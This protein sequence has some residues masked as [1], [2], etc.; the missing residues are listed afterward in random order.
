VSAA[1]SVQSVAIVGMSLA[2]L[3]CAETLRRLGFDGVIHAIGEEVHEPYDR[4]PLSKDVLAGI[5]EPSSTRLRTDGLADLA[6]DLHL[7]RRATSLRADDRVVTLDDGAEVG[8]DAIVIATGAIARRLPATICPPSLPNVH[9]LRTLDDAVRLRAALELSP[10]RVAVIGAGFIGMEVA[11]ACRSRGLEVTVVEALPQPM[12]RG[13]GELLGSTCAQLHRKHGVQIELGVGVAAVDERGIVLADGRRVDADVVL[14]GVGAEPAV[15]WLAGSGLTIDNGV[16]CDATCTASPGIYAAGDVA[17]W[18]NPLFDQL[19]RLEHW[20]NAVEQGMH[21]AQQIVSGDATEFAPVPFVWSDQY[22]CKIQSVGR[23]DADSDLH[24]AHGALDSYK[25]VAL[26]GH[27]GRVVGA[28]GFSQ[29]RLVTQYRRLIAD[30]ASWDDAL[31]KS[32]TE[33][34]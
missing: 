1:V 8:A 19:M 31:A 21:V 3:R 7:G 20:T 13:L 17:R 29:P 28:L 33:G 16:V 15:A 2:G 26:F 32:R 24:I 27:G 12:I 6:L 34:T 14:V 4:P 5:E 9:V 23:F 22:D 11:A 10:A 18:H 30:R 25:F